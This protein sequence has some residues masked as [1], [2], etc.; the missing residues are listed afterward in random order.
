[1]YNTSRIDIQR[2]ANSILFGNGSGAGIINGGTDAAQIGS[3]NGTATVRFGQYGSHR[4]SLNLNQTLIKNQLAIRV[5][6]LHDKKYYQQDP[7]YNRDIRQYAAL[8]YEPEFLK[9]GSA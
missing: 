6:V 7:A 9:K 4:E 3:D 2:G 1:T 8:R 5:A